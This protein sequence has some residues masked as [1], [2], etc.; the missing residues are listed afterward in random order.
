MYFLIFL[1]VLGLLMI[2]MGLSQSI[3]KALV[4]GIIV[5][6]TAFAFV[7]QMVNERNKK[8]QK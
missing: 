4:F 7:L 1:T 3:P 8:K 5:L 2:F 6:L